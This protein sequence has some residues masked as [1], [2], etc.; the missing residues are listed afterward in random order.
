MRKQKTEKKVLLDGHA[1]VF[2][3]CGLVWA[4]GVANRKRKRKCASFSGFALDADLRRRVVFVAEI[5]IRVGLL[6]VLFPPIGFFL[7]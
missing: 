5:L 3:F 4:G 7:L 6:R 1:R 2:Q